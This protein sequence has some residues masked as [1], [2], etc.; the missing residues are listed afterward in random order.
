MILCQ[1]GCGKPAIHITKGSLGTGPFKGAPVHQCAKSSNSCQ[2]VKDRKVASSLVKY[3]TEYPWQTKEIGDKR[4]ATNLKK[5]GH[6]SSVMN[7]DIQAKRKKT[8][9]DRYGVEEPTQNEEIRKKAAVGVKQ[10]YI[11]DPT[12]STKQLQSK[13]KK[14]GDDFADIVSKSRKTQ[15]ANGRWVDPAK[16][17]EWAQYKFRVKYLTAK[18]YK[19]FKDI[20]NPTDLP[21]GRCEYQVD[22]IYS[23]RHG[24]ENNVDPTIIADIANLR[25]L[26]HT[27]N[28]SKHIRSDYT[29]EEL[30]I[31]TKEA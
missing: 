21:I 16:R 28:K 25:L 18:A 15:I 29:L 17:T 14:Y 19:K 31:K 11:N 13:K 8:M 30:L 6:I 27:E 7:P 24:F 12:L 23:I 26:W 1:H 10:S 5:Y 2:A 20:I 4:N 22:H 9:L 3:G